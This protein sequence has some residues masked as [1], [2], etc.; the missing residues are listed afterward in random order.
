MHKLL[1]KQLQKA[2]GPDG[3]IDFERLSALVSLAYDEAD[4]HRER[5][6]RSIS[7]MVEE[8]GE[9][10]AGLEDEIARRTGQLHQSRRELK[11]QNTRFTAALENMSHGISMYDAD[12]KLVVCN[13]QFLELYRLPKRYGRIGTSFRTI[14]EQRVISN[15]AVGDDPIGY[16]EERLAFVTQGIAATTILHLNSGQVI[17][18]HHQPMPGGGWVSTHRD[19]T[20][21]YRLQE[22][23]SHLAYYDALTG[24]ANRHLLQQQIAANLSTSGSFA[25]LFADLDGFKAIN[26]TMGHASGDQLLRDV[27]ARLLACVGDMGMAGRMGGDEFAVVMRTGTSQRDAHALA[28]RL[29]E[30]VRRP[31]I[32]EGQLCDI[33]FSIGIAISPSDG[34]TAE[35]LLRNADLALYAAKN[36]KRGSYCFYEPTMGRAMRDRRQMEADLGIA[37]ERGEFELH[38]QPIL[39]LKTQAFA[40][41][42]ALLR[43]RHP[44]HGMISP[45][46]FIPV[47]E[48]TG[49]IV[50]IGEWVLRE[51]LREAAKWPA[52]LRIAINVSSLQFLRGNMVSLMMNALA[53]TRIAPERVELEITESLFLEN[54]AA[55]LDTLRQLHALGL[56]IALDDFGT[57]YSALSY[58][59]SFPFDKIKIDG[60]F[61][62]ALESAKGAH[63]IVRAVSEIGE[64]M[65]MTTTAEGVETA[66]QLRNINALGYS[67]AQG[68]LIARPMPAAEVHLLIDGEDDAMPSSPL[69]RAS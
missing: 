30:E 5:T 11:L 43:W 4:Q 17:S 1:D 21:K 18:V 45:A 44:E 56:R 59:L 52:H 50:P 68:Y 27:A 61:V 34:S 14:L 49:I 46:R 26:D 3:E 69:Q 19:I 62:R 22:E 32:V 39:N 51:A 48:E 35:A 20:D 58:L 36:N 29:I 42:E 57:G 33:A 53:A 9:F 40:G 38:Y 8:L 13:A 67:E 12:E 66:E 28:L 54:S 2:R 41:F 6:D 16:F 24:L 47:A 60:S 55:N 64:R 31:F 63:A 7:L 23:L 10:Q 15:T 25:L 37:L 65:G